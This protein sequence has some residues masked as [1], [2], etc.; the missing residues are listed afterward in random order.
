[1]KIKYLKDMEVY[2]LGMLHKDVDESD[3]W[4]KII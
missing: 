2:Y 1:M 4:D 3:N